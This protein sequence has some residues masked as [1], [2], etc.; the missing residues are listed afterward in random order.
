MLLGSGSFAALGSELDVAVANVSAPYSVTGVFRIT[1]PS[2]GGSATS[3]TVT[4]EAVRAVAEP[5]GLALLGLGLAVLGG[6]AKRRRQ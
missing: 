6:M 3:L 2:L 5:H 1:A 4:A